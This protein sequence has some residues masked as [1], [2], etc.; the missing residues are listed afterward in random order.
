MLSILAR[1]QSRAEDTILPEHFPPETQE[2]Q[3]LSHLEPVD[4]DELARTAGL[5]IE[6]VKDETNPKFKNSVF[7]GLMRQL[8]DREAVIEGTQIIQAETQVDSRSSL[9]QDFSSKIDVKGKGREVAAENGWADA[10]QSSL[11]SSLTAQTRSAPHPPAFSA[12]RKSV[13]FDQSETTLEDPRTARQEDDE[14]LFWRQ[15]NA[16]YQKYWNALPQPQERHF[17]PEW[18]RLQ[19]DWDH[20]EATSSGIKPITAYS[21]QQNNPYLSGS[22]LTRT[23]RLHSQGN[24]NHEVRLP[25][26]GSL[27]DF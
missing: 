23:H 16:D 20:F 1:L 22:F 5:L 10:F 9:A 15:E 18:D 14:D 12:F 8:R 25:N 3:A 26:M 17:N 13:H 6:A 24:S 27:I 19:S 4:A 11:Q 21:F 2:E 7:L